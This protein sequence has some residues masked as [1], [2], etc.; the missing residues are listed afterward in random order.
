MNEKR[1]SKYVIVGFLV[2]SACFVLTFLINARPSGALARPPFNVLID[3]LH[4]F[5]GP[6]SYYGGFVS[7]IAV[8]I[9]TIV[10]LL[11]MARKETRTVRGRTVSDWIVG[12]IAT[13]IVGFI[14]FFFIM[15]SGMA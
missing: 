7:G 8:Q 3:T 6:I 2:S 14:C 12:L 11:I 15:A 4:S 13:V 1:C 10:F 5:A 9:I